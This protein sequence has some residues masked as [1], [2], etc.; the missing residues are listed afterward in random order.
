MKYKT[1]RALVIGGGVLVGALAIFGIARVVENQSRVELLPAPAA[2][3]YQDQL[4]GLLGKSSNGETKIK[5]LP[6]AGPYKVNVYADAGTWNRAKVDLDRDEKWDEKWRWDDGVVYRAVAANDDEV[7]GPEQ[8]VTGPAS[9]P[10]PVAHT[11]SPPAANQLRD[12]DNLMLELLD[13]PVQSKIKDAS[14]GRP[15]KINL[16]SDDGQRFNRAKVDLDRDDKWDEKW[17]FKPDGTIERQLAPADDENYTERF[18]LEARARWQPL[19]A[20]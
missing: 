5:D 1:F 11:D 6:G 16:Y 3:H 17:T 18:V 19:S 8:I 2:N 7:Y 4:L 10:A 13:Q 14:K 12:V 9:K 15:F 20:G